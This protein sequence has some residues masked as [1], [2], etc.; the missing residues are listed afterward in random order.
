MTIRSIKA[1][2][3]WDVA[4]DGVGLRSGY[5]LYGYYSRLTPPELFGIE[6]LYIVRTILFW[7]LAAKMPKLSQIK[8]NTGM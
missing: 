5:T 7:L 2:G 4:P 1:G 3:E 8:F 6:F